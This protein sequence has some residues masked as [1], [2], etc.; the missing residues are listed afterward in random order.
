MGVTPV[1]GRPGDFAAILFVMFF[2]AET[3]LGAKV[4]RP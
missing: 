1:A 2:V 3:L 4:A